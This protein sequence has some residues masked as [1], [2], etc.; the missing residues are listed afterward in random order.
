MVQ[1]RLP[2][3]CDR[4][5]FTMNLLDEKNSPYSFIVKYKSVFNLSEFENEGRVAYSLTTETN[6]KIN[7]E[8]NN[9]GL[10]VKKIGKFKNHDF[11]SPVKERTID[12][13]EKKFIN[14]KLRKKVPDSEE[15]AFDGPLPN[16][17]D[18]ALLTLLPKVYVNNEK[19]CFGV[20]FDLKSVSV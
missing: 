20:Y 17:E 2:L 5:F 13:A 9:I 8:I 3:L 14:V 1:V 7:T 15:W 10:A 18:D 19:K 12:E 16:P 6:D 11:L 4:K